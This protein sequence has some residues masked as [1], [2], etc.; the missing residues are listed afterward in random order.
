[1]VRRDGGGRGTLY[2]VRH[3]LTDLARAFAM[4][5]CFALGELM[6]QF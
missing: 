2:P 3:S 5:A 4:F 6:D 1:M